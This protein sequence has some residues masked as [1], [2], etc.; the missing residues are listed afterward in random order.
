M[1][2]CAKCGK[3]NIDKAIYCANCGAKL[4]SDFTKSN[5]NGN[6]CP[7]C[8][9]NNLDIATYCEFCG[10]SLGAGSNVSTSSS[11][12]LDS[13]HASSS[14]SNQSNANQ[15]S[16]KGSDKL[17]VCCCY[18][19]AVLFIIFLIL[20]MFLNAFPESFSA[21]FD[22]DFNYLDFDGDG[23]LS[24]EEARQYDP[25]MKDK[26]IGTYFSDADKNNN[27]Y[28]IGHEFDFFRSDVRGSPSS[29]LSVFMFKS[30]SL[31]KV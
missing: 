1:K 3:E 25:Y 17:K 13:T 19:P 10:A 27:G 18:V 28:L 22:D 12:G 7:K 29:I 8:G 30:C 31:N 9:K 5:V 2:K 16:D 21:T 15:K 20:G 11:S 4:G 26:E 24:F 14:S 6:I 23:K